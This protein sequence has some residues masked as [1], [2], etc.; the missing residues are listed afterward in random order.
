MLCPSSKVGLSG[1]VSHAISIGAAFAALG[2]LVIAPLLFEFE[3]P[4]FTAKCSSLLQDAG[5]PGSM[6]VFMWQKDQKTVCHCLAAI[7]NLASDSTQD[8]SSLANAG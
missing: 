7:L 2:L 8:A 4:H 6:G 1:S 5:A 3:W